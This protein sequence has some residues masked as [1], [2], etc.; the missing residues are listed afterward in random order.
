M[1]IVADQHIKSPY[2]DVY[3]HN[4]NLNLNLDYRIDNIFMHGG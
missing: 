2:K 4:D 3:I 1:Q